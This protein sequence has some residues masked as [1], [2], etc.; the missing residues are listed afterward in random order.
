MVDSDCLSTTFLICYFTCPELK[1]IMSALIFNY[2]LNNI[3]SPL[4]PD[5]DKDQIKV[6]DMNK[7]MITEAIDTAKK[8]I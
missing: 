2:F 5:F 1:P 4:M 6:A 3:T 8:A 7:D